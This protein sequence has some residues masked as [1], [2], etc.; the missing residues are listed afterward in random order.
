LRERPAFRRRCIERGASIFHVL[1]EQ[2]CEVGDDPMIKPVN[3]RLI[4][5]S[6]DDLGQPVGEMAQPIHQYFWVNGAGGSERLPLGKSD[7]RMS[8]FIWKVVAGVGRLD[9]GVMSPEGC[10]GLSVFRHQ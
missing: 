3:Q 5:S 8:S 10:R 6:G 1:D 7:E 9:P 4:A 2:G